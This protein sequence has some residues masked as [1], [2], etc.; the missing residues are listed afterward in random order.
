M[1]MIFKILKTS[2]DISTN[3]GIRIEHPE[4][5]Y[6]LTHVIENTEHFLV[7][8]VPK[9][10]GFQF[11]QGDEIKVYF[12]R[13]N[14]RG[15]EFESS[16]I[17]IVNDPVG[18]LLIKHTSGMTEYLTPVCIQK[19]VQLDMNFFLIPILS[20]EKMFKTM[21]IERVDGRIYELGDREISFKIFPEKI[22]KKTGN[23]LKKDS[24]IKGIFSIPNKKKPL[25]ELDF[26]AKITKKS[27]REIGGKPNEP[28]QNFIQC[29]AIFT[30]ITDRSRNHI[31][32][33]IYSIE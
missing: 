27:H 8:M 17:G 23:I 15:Y 4:G 1:G 12:W 3:Q 6:F 20:H 28:D 33:Y 13:E 11:N 24:L 10:R 22:S 19:N 14:D 26:V 2:H 18:L 16:V 25:V 7:L 21:E 32:H 30:N 31:L 29:E 9:K 5:G